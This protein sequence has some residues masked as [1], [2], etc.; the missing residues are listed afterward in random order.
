MLRQIDADVRVRGLVAGVRRIAIMGELANPDLDASQGIGDGNEIGRSYG[1]DR[2]VREG[3]D[4]ARWK[5]ELASEHERQAP[6]IFPGPETNRKVD[7]TAGL[8]A[9]EKMGRNL[10]QVISGGGCPVAAHFSVTFV[11]SRTMTCSVVSAG[12]IIGGAGNRAEC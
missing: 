1:R 7:A 9:S 10:V 3:D 5:I 4:A 11:A 8:T 6:G 12:L 2:N